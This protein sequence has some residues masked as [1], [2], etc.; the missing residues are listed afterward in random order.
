MFLLAYVGSKTMVIFNGSYLK[1]HEAT[2]IPQTAVNRY[3]VY[4]IS[5]NFNIEEYPTLENC[6]FGAVILRKNFD[7]YKYKYFG[8]GVAFERKE[9]FS[10]GNGFGR[11]CF[12]VD[13]SS[14]LHVDDKK[15]DNLILGEGPIRGLHG[16]T[17]TARKVFN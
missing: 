1:Q 16:T 8:N 7:I 17:L 6:L 4:K 11:N 14:F 13:M 5:K 2:L 3:I 9:T 15:R 12:G 10:V